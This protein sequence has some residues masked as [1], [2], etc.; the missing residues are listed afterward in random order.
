MT[1]K[2]LGKK[3]LLRPVDKPRE[4]VEGGIVVLSSAG[5]DSHR[6]ALVEA[7]GPSYAGDLCPG[8]TVIIKPF[9]GQEIVV[10]GERMLVCLE[11]EIEAVIE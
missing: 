9:A 1:F 8:E 11:A 5:R 3:I 7:L 4:S 6:Q 10:N 2:P